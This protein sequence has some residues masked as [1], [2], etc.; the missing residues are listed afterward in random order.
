MIFK[1][2]AASDDFS[3][4]SPTL[5]QILQAREERAAR[6]KR[7]LRRPDGC[8]VCLTVNMPGAVKSCPASERIFSYGRLALYSTLPISYAQ[9]HEGPTGYEG[10]FTVQGDARTVKSRTCALEDNH[11]LGR[12]W[13]MDVLL[14]GG[15]ALGRR[16]LGLPP[17]RCLLCRQ[18]AV[19]CARSRAHPV[20]D[21]LSEI[22]RR[23]SEWEAG[24]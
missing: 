17:R 18:D 15:R 22:G 11:P 1:P 20:N 12:L 13:D 16:D 7:L 9:V 14:P 24:R 10:Y 6:Q 5:A 23:L 21:L 19:I 3:G 8:L 2:A 4:P